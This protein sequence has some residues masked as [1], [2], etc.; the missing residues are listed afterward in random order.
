MG[1]LGK[2]AILLEVSYTFNIILLY[3]SR[4]IDLVNA[5]DSL[6]GIQPW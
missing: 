5:F 2:Q 6:W 4:L 1:S 3:S